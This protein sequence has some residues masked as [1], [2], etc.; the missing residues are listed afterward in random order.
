MESFLC[1]I[2][3]NAVSGFRMGGCGKFESVRVIELTDPKTFP[4]AEVWLEW[5]SEKGA[6]TALRDGLM[7]DGYMVRVKD[8]NGESHTK[9]CS[10][11]RKTL[12]KILKENGY[13]W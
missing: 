8:S 12:L 9:E 7:A 11:I 10:E 6:D 13:S 5:S 1:S 2:G 4:G 3:L